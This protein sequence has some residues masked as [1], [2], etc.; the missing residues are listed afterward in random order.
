MGKPTRKTVSPLGFEPETS[1]GKFTAR[2]VRSTEE[3][4]NRRFTP[5]FLAFLKEHNGGVP[6]ARY[7]KLGRNV[8]V[9]DAF[10]SLVPDYEN[11]PLGQLDIGVV[12]SQI[13]D[14]LNDSLVPFAAL[15]PGDFLCFDH[16][17]T[18]KPRVVLWDHERSDQRGPVTTPVADD[19]EQ[20]LGMLF[21]E[22]KTPA[23]TKK[24]QPVKRAAK[25]VRPTAA[26]SFA[27]KQ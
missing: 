2:Y 15:F 3:M 22:K 23:R 6:K 24:K 11:D 25:K 9:V 14:R 5:A 10:L 17:G 26:R 18:R 4:I 7:F 20:F 1:A 19:F 27:A 8:K 21:E 13:E 16:K 12:W